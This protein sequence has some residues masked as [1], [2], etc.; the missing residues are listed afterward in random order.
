MKEEQ[1]AYSFFSS[2]SPLVLKAG[3]TAGKGKQKKEFLS[4]VFFLGLACS[5]FFILSRRVHRQTREKKT[6]IVIT[7]VQS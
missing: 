2:L 4:R 3:K 6:Y 1:D 7:T 5:S